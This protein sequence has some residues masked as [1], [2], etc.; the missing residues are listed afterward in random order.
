MRKQ[1]EG[2]YMDIKNTDSSY[3][4]MPVPYWDW[5]DKQNEIVEFM[6]QQQDCDEVKF[7]YP[8]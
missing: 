8:L 4:L 7:I 6:N 3:E 5:I 1:G 2:T